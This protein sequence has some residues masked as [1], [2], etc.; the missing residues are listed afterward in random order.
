M[1]V[2]DKVVFGIMF[3]IKFDDPVDHRRVDQRAVAG[4]LDD[5]IRGKTQ[6]GLVMPVQQIGSMSPETIQPFLPA[7]VL[8]GII[9][10]VQGSG[11]NDPS[12]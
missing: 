7:D 3:E 4:D 5:G 10:R 8:D 2:A 11:D 12:H 9:L 6:R 1:K